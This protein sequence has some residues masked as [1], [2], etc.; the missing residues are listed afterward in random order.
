MAIYPISQGGSL[1]SCLSELFAKSP[2][3]R[4]WETL[5]LSQ[6]VSGAHI[7]TLEVLI[8]LGQ[9]GVLPP[10]REANKGNLVT[11]WFI[12]E[13]AGTRCGWRTLIWQ[14]LSHEL[15]CGG[16]M[17]QS[18]CSSLSQK[19]GY[20]SKLVGWLISGEKTDLCWE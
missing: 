15:H 11:W 6:G 19:L 9:S 18:P 5:W 3:D 17:S 2:A 1:C 14:T 10:P 16:G 4:L 7:H 8:S 20:R 13:A 12:L